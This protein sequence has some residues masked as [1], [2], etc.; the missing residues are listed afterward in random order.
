[1]APL[2]EISWARLELICGI[3][4]RGAIKAPSRWLAP[5]RARTHARTRL[6]ASLFSPLAREQW[7]LR[8]GTEGAPSAAGDGA[9]GG[10]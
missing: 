2:T 7:A 10:S 5:I 3:I 9:A 8:R 1:M 6:A 4:P